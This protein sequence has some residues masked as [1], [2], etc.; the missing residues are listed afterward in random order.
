MQSQAPNQKLKV[1]LYLKTETSK[2][3]KGGSL[4]LKTMLSH[5]WHAGKFSET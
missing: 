3:E 4:S 2:N 1:L 5:S